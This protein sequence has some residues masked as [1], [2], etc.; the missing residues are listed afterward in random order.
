M[1]ARDGNGYLLAGKLFRYKCIFF[2]F[3]SLSVFKADQTLNYLLKNYLYLLSTCCSVAQS[4]PPTQFVLIIKIKS[5]ISKDQ[6]SNESK[7]STPSFFLLNIYGTEIFL[8]FPFSCP[9]LPALI[10]HVHPHRSVLLSI[11]YLF[12]MSKAQI[13][14]FL[15][16]NSLAV[17]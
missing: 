11:A 13:N 9:V 17:Q 2:I 12:H 6:R 14:L 10:P 8:F 16:I 15:C 5:N 4:S 7:K 1:N 3:Y